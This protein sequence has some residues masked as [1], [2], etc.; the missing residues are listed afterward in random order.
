MEKY[1]VEVVL[2]RKGFKVDKAILSGSRLESGLFKLDGEVK[3]P[4]KRVGFKKYW[5]KTSNIKDKIGGVDDLQKDTAKL[6]LEQKMHLEKTSNTFDP[7][8]QHLHHIQIQDSITNRITEAF[9][10]TLC[11]KP[12]SSCG[13]ENSTMGWML[14][15]CGIPEKHDLPD[16][17]MLRG[18]CPES[19]G[20]LY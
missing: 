1:E 4:L 17:E 2:S 10:E 3:L 6:E 8:T 11:S 9:D 7:G 19:S 14:D 5:D 20:N 12:L 15:S 18:V 13:L 16:M